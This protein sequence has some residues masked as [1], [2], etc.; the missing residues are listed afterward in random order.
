MLF[1]VI[2]YSIRKFLSMPKRPAESEALGLDADGS[3]IKTVFFLAGSY[4]KLHSPFG[5]LP[6][7]S[8][9]ARRQNAPVAIQPA[10]SKSA[11]T[12]AVILFPEFYISRLTDLPKVRNPT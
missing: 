11:T 8:L 3:N 6:C 5:Q 9:A 1:D 2:L 4:P 12:G 7:F 10:N